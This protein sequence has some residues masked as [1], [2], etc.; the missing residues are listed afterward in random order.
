MWINLHDSLISNVPN[1]VYL[2]WEV[3][4]IQ[5]WY[6]TP[7]GWSPNFCWKQN[8]RECSLQL[9]G[10]VICLCLRSPKPPK[11]SFDLWLARRSISFANDY[12]IYGVWTRARTLILCNRQVYGEWT[13]F[14]YHHNTYKMRNDWQSPKFITLTWQKLMTLV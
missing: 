9:C 6:S 5:T 7:A 12:A 11:R 3:H 8:V 10:K 4:K 1:L 13:V 14:Y 2:A